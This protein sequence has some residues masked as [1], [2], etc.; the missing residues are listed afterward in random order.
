[1]SCEWGEKRQD[2][3]RRGKMGKET[4]GVRTTIDVFVLEGTHGGFT[5][6]PRHLSST[7]NTPPHTTI[8]PKTSTHHNTLTRAP[9]SIIT[10]YTP[11]N[12]CMYFFLVGWITV[13]FTMSDMN[14]SLAS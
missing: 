2:G 7:F 6:L 9:I 14:V 1:M 8:L 12:D 4:E 5:I 3:L 11:R 10:S 13:F